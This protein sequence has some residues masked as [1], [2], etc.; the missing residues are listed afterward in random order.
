MTVYDTTRAYRV[1]ICDLTGPRLDESGQP[2]CS[3]VRAHIVDAG[4]IFR[5]GPFRDQEP[6]LR[7]GVAGGVAPAVV[8]AGLAEGVA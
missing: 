1:L 2:D 4:E 7:P 6:A 3:E 5:S 8:G